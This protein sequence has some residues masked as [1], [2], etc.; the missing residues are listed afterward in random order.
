MHV[1][2]IIH[3]DKLKFIN[4]RGK[5]MANNKNNTITKSNKFKDFFKKKTNKILSICLAAVLVVGTTLAVVLPITLKKRNVDVAFKIPALNLPISER[6]ALT[7]YDYDNLGE[8][9]KTLREDTMVVTKRDL[10]RAETTLLPDEYT[11]AENGNNL[12][13]YYG[14]QDAEGNP[15]NFGSKYTTIDF[16]NYYLYPGDGLGNGTGGANT[17]GRHFAAEANA[18]F[19]GDSDAY[20]KYG[21]YYKFMLLSQGHNLGIESQNRA[22]QTLNNPQNQA[23]FKAW[24]K[25][26]P[27]ADLQYGAVVGDNNAVEKEITL[28][29]IYRAYHATGL[30]LPAGEAIDLKIENLQ[31][32]E[33]ISVVV[34]LQ[35]TLAYAATGYNT[36][37][38]YK[39]AE[40]AL[41]NGQF[42]NYFASTTNEETGVTSLS[43]HSFLQSQMLRQNNRMPWIHATFTFSKNGTYTLGTPFGGIMHIAMN[44]CYSQVKTTFTGAVETPHYILG[45]TTP[46]Y[47]DTYLRNAPGVVG[48]LDTEN[49]Q[50]VG[51]VFPVD[52]YPSNSVKNHSLR[53]T[54]T[55]EIE[56]LGMLWH[57]FFAVNESFTGGTYNR[58]N[59]VKFDQHVPAG[60]AVALGGYNY[61]CPTGWFYNCMSYTNMTTSGNWGTLHE[62]GHNHASSYGTFWGFGDGKEGEVHNNALTVLSYLLFTDIPTSVGNNTVGVEHGFV[63]NPY[64]SLSAAL[65]I[66]NRNFSDYSELGYFDMLDMYSNI[67]HSFSPE[68]FYELLYTYKANGDSA[69]RETATS[70]RRSGFAYRCALVY[71]MNFTNYYNNIYRA[72]ITEDMY[73]SEQLAYLK[74]LPNYE[75]I[76]CKYAGGIDGIKTGGDYIVNFGEDITLDL[77]TN[78]I[79]SLDT[80]DKKGFTILNVGNPIYGSITNLGNGKYSY[81]FNRNYAG[82]SD[83]FS[84][85]VKLDDGVVHEFTVYLRIGYN[86]GSLTSYQGLDKGTDIFETVEPQIAEKEPTKVENVNV[87]GTGKYTTAANTWEVKYL[88]F[89]WKAPKSGK[90]TFTLYYDDA[91]K[92]YFGTNFNNLE[93]L[94]TATSHSG[95]NWMEV[96]DKDIIVTA[97]QYYAL[98]LFNV[99]TGGGGHA[100]VGCF[101]E[102]D[103]NRQIKTETMYHPYMSLGA[104]PVPYKFE[105]V[106]LVSKKDGIAVETTGTDKGKWEVIEA[107]TLA[108]GGIYYDEAS[109]K[110]DTKKRGHYEKHTQ[111]ILPPEAYDEY[112]NEIEG[113]TG[114]RIE[115]TQYYNMWN[116]LIDG[117][118]STHYH[119]PYNGSYNETNLSKNPHVFVIDTKNLQSM[120]YFSVTTRNNANSYIEEYEFSVST[121]NVNYKLIRA[122]TRK[123]YKNTTI[124]IE[125][126]SQTV[127]YL[128][129]V[130]KK[131]SGGSF[132]VL[133]EIDAGIQ[134][135]TQRLLSTTSPL[136]FTTKNWQNSANIQGLKH[137]YLVSDKKNEKMVLRFIGTEIAL[138]GAVGKDFGMVDVK[139]D[140]KYVTT[141]DFSSTKDEP[142]K[143]LYILEDLE[144]TTHTV[145]IITKSNGRVMLNMLG[146]NYLSQ[147]INAPNIY[148]ERALTNT[149]IVFVILFAAILTLILC[150]LFIPKFRNFMGGNKGILWMDKKL[151]EGRKKRKEKRAE[152]R[153][154]KAEE[155]RI[156]AIAN[157]QKVNSEKKT[158]SL[159]NNVTTNTKINNKVSATNLHNN[160]NS[161]VAK[162]DSSKIS[163]S[164]S[165][166]K[167]QASASSKSSNDNKT[168]S[169]ALNST[170]SP[171][172]HK[173]NTKSIKSTE[174]KTTKPADKTVKAKN[175]QAGKKTKPTNSKSASNTKST[176]K[177]ATKTAAKNKK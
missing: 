30:Y 94:Y 149:V 107:P 129:L 121:D 105:P 58:G 131:A 98:R 59:I 20:T 142:R 74:S 114:D 111:Y 103:A 177:T 39:S 33:S 23:E 57:S 36:I 49:G 18:M 62:I 160:Q 9:V 1:F 124:T 134:T 91:I 117:S 176:T 73:T 92:F 127:R 120:N 80:A 32:G 67:M 26:H 24:L 42:S 85:T 54:K 93:L 41:L 45:V 155:K 159:E 108:H 2:D 37:T 132:S 82:T 7:K 146:I 166:G 69:Y 97:G 29:P 11:I 28:D 133:S 156:A 5:L 172:A 139:V 71:G 163:E 53:T 27:A 101:F 96:N 116:Y 135:H 158:K 76:A 83:Q 148:K 128:K 22:V 154:Q 52:G 167:T 140:G 4:S 66:K 175:A 3:N 110:A 162:K 168:T 90:V 21:L 126:D 70:N 40:T 171:I 8:T 109:D 44:N 72:K 79:S 10:P 75:P 47:Y 87:A 19:P 143:L 122:G 152:K 174:D 65:S 12:N 86:S 14:F 34:A 153:A 138:Y 170:K 88:D 95:S 130:V 68:K 6:Y 35:N 78:T 55:E 113:F 115:Y 102:G 16:D 56:K 51:P 38:G 99:N 173:N 15:Y 50:L 48:V 100:Y 77:L 157:G 141:I 119:T 89:Y 64:T 118:T 104:N 161:K 81:R 150:L 84:F 112:G 137:G 164:H 151:E 145:E 63:A 106:Y 13:Y 60:A 123:D 125:F 31:P 136:V 17:I 43:G 165:A 61:A 46:E 169:S 144:D 25:K 147:L